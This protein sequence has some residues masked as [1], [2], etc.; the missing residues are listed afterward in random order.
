MATRR[1]ATK[2]PAEDESSSPHNTPPMARPSGNNN[3]AIGNDAI[4]ISNGINNFVDDNF[5]GLGTIVNII[6]PS[7]VWPVLV[8]YAVLTATIDFDRFPTGAVIVGYLVLMMIFRK[9]RISFTWTTTLVLII[10]LSMYFCTGLVWFWVKW[11]SFLR[12]AKISSIIIQVP[13][14][15]ETAFYWSMLKRLYPHVIYWPV[16]DRKSVV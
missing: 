9:I 15:S 7:N 6:K 11:W 14:G 8:L 5:S 2:R 3:V 4:D 13:D 10:G 1:L 12:D 16:S